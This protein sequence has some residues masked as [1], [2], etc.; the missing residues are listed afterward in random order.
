[1]LFSAW[2]QVSRFLTRVRCRRPNSATLYGNVANPAGAASPT[3]VVTLLAQDTAASLKT[4]DDTGARRS[5]STWSSGM[6]APGIL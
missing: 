5:P 1:M 6:V 2:V 3:A 4:T